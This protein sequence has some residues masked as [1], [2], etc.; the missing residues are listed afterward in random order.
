MMKAIIK[1]GGGLLLAV[2]ISSN[3]AA[4]DQAPAAAGAASSASPSIEDL[5]PDKVVAKGTGF[6]IKRSQL[7]Q[8]VI[9]AKAA[10]ATRGQSVPDDM[11]PQLEL[12]SLEYL[13][14]IQLLNGVATADDKAKGELD[15]DKAY[16]QLKK[17]TPSEA[18]MMRGLKAAGLTPE[19]YHKS[20]AQKAT[21][22]AVLVSKVNV[23]DDDIKKY[24]DDHPDKF[25]KPETVKLDFI[26]MGA[27]DVTTHAPL[28]DDQ[29]ELRRKALADIRSRVLKGED[30]KEL[31]KLYS[32]DAAAK[33]T[34]GEMTI[35]RGIQQIPQQF[36]QTAF[37]L[38]TNEVSDIISTPYGFHIIKMIQ[39]VPAGKITLADA[40][41]DIRDFL[42][43]QAIQKFLPKYDAQL[44]KDAHVEIVDPKLKELEDKMA[45]DSATSAAAAQ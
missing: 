26:T 1:F 20:L 7:D 30:M 6:E 4:P 38:K 44:R 19:T 21:A 3:A 27:P 22:R 31:A 35:Y 16:E 28:P 32:E 40:K 33:D 18:V 37:S 43:T 17:S 11:L 41:S 5:L 8:A 13:I 36:E 23:S 12:K 25:E 2:A 9:N 39:R 42:E 15:A 10:A 14:Q 45:A 29:K 24:Y 34:G